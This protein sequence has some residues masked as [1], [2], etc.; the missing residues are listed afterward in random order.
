MENGRNELHV[1]ETLAD[2]SRLIKEKPQLINKTDDNGVYPIHLAA[3]QRDVDFVKLLLD[4]SASLNSV[5]NQGKTPLHYAAMADNVSVIEFIGTCKDVDLEC[6]DN[7]LQSTPLILSAMLNN[8]SST[9]AL[10]KLGCKLEA[11]DRSKSNA[12]HYAVRNNQ[13][14]LTT[15]L[16]QH[17]LST[18]EKDI[19][20]CTCLHYAATN[21]N[22][23]I[24][25]LLIASNANLMALNREGHIPMHLAAAGGH[26]QVLKE[27]L[28]AKVPFAFCSPNNNSTALYYGSLSGNE[29]IIRILV[30]LGSEVFH[31]CNGSQT[32]LHAAASRGNL[33][34]LKILLELG[35]NVTVSDD[36]G[37]IPLHKAAK[38]GH[39]NCVE[40]LL[41]KA[42][43]TVRY[44]DNNSH[45]PMAVAAIGKHKECMEILLQKEA[46]SLKW[47]D[48]NGMNQLHWAACAGHDTL[49]R[50]LLKTTGPETQDKK[51]RTALHWAISGA[52]EETVRVLLEHGASIS[53]ICKEDN[54]NAI[55]YASMLGA[56]SLLQ[57][58]FGARIVPEVNISNSNG[59]PLYFAAYRGHSSSVLFLLQKEA[60]ISFKGPGG[61]TILHAASRGGCDLE[62]I[63]LLISKGQSETAENDAGETPIHYAATNDNPD[64]L[65]RF[66]ESNNSKKVNLLTKKKQTPLHY[67]ATFGIT[68]SMDI[69][70]GYSADPSIQDHQN[71]TPLMM[72]EKRSHADCI[73]ILTK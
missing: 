61:N 38:Y 18:Q 4:H 16:L 54:C 24:V 63:K 44:K 6:I 12:L 39:L 47:T 42:P 19:H 52:N 35:A 2:A 21:G 70:L 59:S 68:S 64:I 20:G 58:M 56:T 57:M 53:T 73:K 46:T 36:S 72:A 10:I 62:T 51:G 65:K 33:D 43:H 3:A 31:Q 26:T 5:T 40:F 28:S 23:E 30:K 55:Q 71:N 22:A 13:R 37:Q 11:S 41:R 45:T 29:E 25:R 67:A 49:V 34:S 48:R 14:E 66:L 32:P 15:M 27:F 60:D 50:E 17:G 69:L 7:S 8:P 1:A 9:I